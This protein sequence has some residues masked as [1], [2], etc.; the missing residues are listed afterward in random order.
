MLIT[1]TLVWTVFRVLILLFKSSENTEIKACVAGG[2]YKIILHFPLS[3]KAF[4]EGSLKDQA[5]DHSWPHATAPMC[6]SL[7][8]AYFSSGVF[9]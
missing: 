8:V 3:S 4:L 1:Q 7:S 6:S 2:C 9:N 5:V